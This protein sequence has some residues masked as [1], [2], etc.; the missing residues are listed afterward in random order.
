MNKYVFTLIIT[1]LLSSCQSIVPDLKVEPNKKSGAYYL[2]DGPEDNPPE[3]LDKIPDAQPKYEALSKRANRPYVAFDK[4][5]VPMQKIIPFEEEGYAS[6]YGKRYHGRKTSIGE[7]YDMYQMTGAHK[8]LPLPCYIKVTNLENK[9]SVIIRVND[10]GPFIDERIVDLSYAAAQ[11]LRII[12]KGSELVKIEM[13]NPSLAKKNLDQSDN[14]SSADPSIK[15][16]YIQAGAFSSEDNATNL[17]NKLTTIIFKN[18]L[19]IRKIN[20]NSLYLVT[21]GPYDTQK[22][23]EK[24]LK[25]ISKKIQLNS[26]IISE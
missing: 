14:T 1:F 12:E 3:N 11:R 19:N 26:F 2:D 17:I 23:A 9:L 15:D 22:F 5:Y 8:T 13:L 16:F 10:R 7:T 25:D 4:K 21:I 18:S 24:A 20:K 6:W